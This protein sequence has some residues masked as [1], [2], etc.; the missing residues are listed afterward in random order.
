M[1]QTLLS[2]DNS[3][4][5]LLSDNKGGEDMTQDNVTV[6][7]WLPFKSE[8][9]GELVI[10]QDDLKL[11]LD[12]SDFDTH[13][14][15]YKLLN[16]VSDINNHPFLKAVDFKVLTKNRSDLK[17]WLKGRRITILIA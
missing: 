12:L 15:N 1:T 7:G 2:R 16:H 4:F 8:K 3:T 11:D 6:Q 14:D 13:P 5:Q 10:M 17:R 9:V